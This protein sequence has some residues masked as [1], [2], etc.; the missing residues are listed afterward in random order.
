MICWICETTIEEGEKHW[1]MLVL[2]PVKARF[3]GV[4]DN[5]FPMDNVPEW[6]IRLY[7]EGRI[8][9]DDLITP[10]MERKTICSECGEKRKRVLTEDG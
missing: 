1:I 3:L 9:F 2:P 8:S 6:K 5:L 7:D 4:E 10:E